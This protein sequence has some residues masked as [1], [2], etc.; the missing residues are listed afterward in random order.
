MSASFLACLL[1]AADGEKKGLEGVWQGTLDLGAAKLRFVLRFTKKAEKLEGVLDSPDEGLAGLPL[2]RIEVKGEQVRFELRATRAVVEG[3]LDERH[4]ELKGEWKQGPKPLPI[5]FKRTDKPAVLA[6]PQTPKKPYPYEEHEVVFENKK[7][8]VKL[9]G[10]LTL[11]KGKGKVPAVLLVTGSGPQDRDE[12]ILGHKPFLVI[13]DHLTRRGIAVLRYD[14]RGVGK[15][16]GDHGK[17]TTADFADD[18]RA[19]IAFLKGHERI[20]P[21]RVGLAGHSEGGIIGASLGASKEVSFLVLLAGSAF[22]GADILRQQGQALAKAVGADKEQ[23]RR[24]LVFH[25]TAFKALATH[26]DNREALKMFS[27]AMKA[28]LEKADLMGAKAEDVLKH[29]EGQFR[30][31]SSPWFRHFIA[32]D[33]RPDLR[34]AVCPV[35][36][37]IGEKDLQILPGDNLPEFRKALKDNKDATVKELPKLNHLFQACKTGLPSEYGRIEETFAPTALELI[38]EWVAARTKAKER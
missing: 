36:A 9:A 10:T 32:H 21:E 35:L 30:I 17:A 4:T 22:P 14:D 6:R 33:P 26:A 15:S 18:A 1:L 27:A 11:P 2:T 13:A 5:V 20:D 37:L 7:A 34:K 38:G 24:Q 19:G 28:E 29:L 12:T 16:T 8:G 3:K 23:Q 25:E 31:V